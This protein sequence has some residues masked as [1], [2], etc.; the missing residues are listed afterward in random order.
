VIVVSWLCREAQNGLFIAVSSERRTA[1]DAVSMRLT[2]QHQLVWLSTVVVGVLPVAVSLSTEPLNLNDIRSDL[3][4]PAVTNEKPQSGHRV[5]QTNPGYENW[6]VA[7]ALYLPTDWN[8]HKQFP[9]LFE[10][11]GNGNFQNSLG[12]HSDGSIES[13]QM[14]YGL[15]A[16]RGVI[17][18]SLPF[19]DP[20]TRA[21]SR[22]W[23]G[24]PDAT[25][26]YCK[27]T[28][29]RI[30]REYGG[31]PKRL[32]LIGFSRGAIAC[33]YIGLRDDEIAKLWCGF[34]AH[35]HYDGVR[36]WNYV[37]SDAPSA[38]KRLER[39]GSRPQLIS[40]EESTTEVETYLNQAYLQGE[41][42]FVTLP[43]HNHS[44]TWTIKDLPVR[45]RAREWLSNVLRK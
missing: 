8:K 25:A 5:W 17:W 14:G 36:Q 10:Y 9:V 38:K 31:D 6:Q 2:L 1:A 41:F 37:D 26:K 44:S 34:I 32:V 20:Q 22:V 40:H 35:S 15:S 24:D 7:H 42:T 12:D 23:W 28:V 21:H 29:A 4:V 45:T 3:T 11:P 27:Q 18:V 39:L 19:V 16:G 13:C 30:C 43:Y 33:N